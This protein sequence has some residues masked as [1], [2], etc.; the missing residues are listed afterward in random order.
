MKKIFYCFSLLILFI[1]SACAS[2]S[3]EEGQNDSSPTYKPLIIA[4][5]GAS[6]LEPEHTYL[7]YDRAKT[8]NADYIEI[9]LRQT[10]DNQL[11]AIHDEEVDRVTDGSGLVENLTLDQLKD[12]H[13]TKD[14][15]ILT[16]QEIVN[17]YKDS[18]N[19]YIET[20]TDTK[21]NI[22][23][24]EQVVSILESQDLINKG[25][26][27][28]ESFSEE[29]MIKIHELNEDIPFVRLL[30]KA[31]VEKL[32]DHTLQHIGDYAVGVGI[33]AGSVDADLVTKIHDNNLKLH[34]YYYDDERKLTDK[35]LALKV[36]GIF[37]NNPEYAI[38]KVDSLN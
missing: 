15:K 22:E 17:H 19:Y 28:L 5:R 31:E 13:V 9:D 27:I 1:L 26:V 4:H 18:V 20:R 32:D 29:S 37:T 21:G 30:R 25:K 12:L 11:V 38:S 33:Y 16:L 7:S 23:M 8:D 35:M 36:D 6:E 34:V 3:N 2:A 14:Q 10:K 24:E